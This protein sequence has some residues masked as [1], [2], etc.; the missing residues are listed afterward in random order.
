MKPENA[1]VPPTTILLTAI[2]LI[3]AVFSNSGIKK[4]FHLHFN[5]CEYSI[6]LRHCKT[7]SNSFS[8]L[9]DYIISKLLPVRSLLFVWDSIIQMFSGVSRNVSNLQTGINQLN[10]VCTTWSHDN[11]N[12]FISEINF[13]F[14]FVLSDDQLNKTIYILMGVISLCVLIIV[15]LI[16]FLV[17]IKRKHTKQLVIIKKRY[18]QDF[19]GDA[20]NSTLIQNIELR[21]PATVPQEGMYA[22]MGPTKE[23]SKYQTLV[24]GVD[25]Q[26]I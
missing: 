21:P 1:P 8:R 6:G 18:P 12:S 5:I 13:C 24:S 19:S 26:N 25:Y 22:E 20:Q 10:V 11:V 14:Y 15:V 4:T 7:T 16:I 9:L 3:F 17:C 2:F 23:E